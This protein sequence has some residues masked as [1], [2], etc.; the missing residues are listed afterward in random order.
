ML[1]VETY[2]ADEV[3]ELPGDQKGGDGGLSEARKEV[4]QQ[5]TLLVVLVA[6]VV[7]QLPAPVPRALEPGTRFRSSSSRCPEN[8]SRKS[9]PR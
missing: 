1:H 9:K 6:K 8:R 2:I 3:A 4:T 5:L 7:R